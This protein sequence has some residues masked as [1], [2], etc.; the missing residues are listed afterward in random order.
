MF[1]GNWGGGG[2]GGGAKYFFSGPKFL[3]SHEQLSE[4]LLKATLPFSS[5]QLSSADLSAE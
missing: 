4:D 3:P 2:G 1:A 5:A